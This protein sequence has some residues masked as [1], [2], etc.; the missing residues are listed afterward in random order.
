M[1]FKK[2]STNHRLA[3]CKWKKIF[4]KM[5]SPKRF[6]IQR[7]SNCYRWSIMPWYSFPCALHFARKF[8]NVPREHVSNLEHMRSIIVR[9]RLGTYLLCFLSYKVLYPASYTT[10]VSNQITNIN[11]EWNWIINFYDSPY[12]RQSRCTIRVSF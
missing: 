12:Y 6:Q 7:K 9:Y 10:Y 2:I 8:L 4:R 1:N 5:Y 11:R 3:S